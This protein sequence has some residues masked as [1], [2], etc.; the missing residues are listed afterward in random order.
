MRYTM[1]FIF[2]GAL[3][4]SSCAYIPQTISLRPNVT[5]PT[6]TVG[7]GR[8]VAVTVVDDRYSTTLG[9]RGAPGF[10]AKVS[11]SRDLASVVQAA[12][13]DG[14]RNQGFD[15]VGEKSIDGRELRIEIRNLN[16]IF[17]PVLFYGVVRTYYSMKAFCV[18][19]DKRLYERVYRGEREE[20]VVAPPGD[21]S[22]EN[23][24]NET[25]STAIEELL[26]D[27]QL[28]KCLAQ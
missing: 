4:M 7:G 11:L 27:G 23:S 13:I 12:V 20:N 3:L 16:Y 1:A 17:T 8:T 18:L 19:G 21:Q 10:G 15:P 28:S 14:L 5:G 22:N 2:A 24:V 26:N 25:L 9:T 6:N